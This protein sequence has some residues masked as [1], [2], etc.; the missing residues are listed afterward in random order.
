M[1]IK[2]LQASVLG[3]ESVLYLPKIAE[4]RGII[5]QLVDKYETPAASWEYDQA[6]GEEQRTIF[7]EVKPATSQGEFVGDLFN[8]TEDN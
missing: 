7:P 2:L 8:Y 4:A 3:F 5:Q 6:T 1:N